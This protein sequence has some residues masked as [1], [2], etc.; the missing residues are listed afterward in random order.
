MAAFY[1]VTRRWG[2][3]FKINGNVV[4]VPADIANTV[5]VLPRLSVET[6]TIKVNL[7]RRLEYK[8]SALNV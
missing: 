3:H 7:K 2:K 1:R 6:G 8:S 4:N 5:S